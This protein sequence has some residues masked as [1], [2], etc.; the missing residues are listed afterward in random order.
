MPGC[1]LEV[2]LLIVITEQQ[3]PILTHFHFCT[4]TPADA[5]LWTR[6]YKHRCCKGKHCKQ[7]P[8]RWPDERGN[9]HKLLP[10]HLEDIFYHIK[11]N[12][13]EGKKEEEVDV[14]IEIPPKIL[15]DV[16]DELFYKY[17]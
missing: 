5:G 4:S 8:H 7:G 2:L 6:V 11:G 16:L 15:K 10:R 17:F 1:T 13:K 9:H 3:E 12:M 14:N